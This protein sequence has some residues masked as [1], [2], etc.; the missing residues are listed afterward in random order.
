M[1][2]EGKK[3]KMD[4]HEK[5]ERERKKK[6]TSKEWL[7]ILVHWPFFPP[8]S[9]S[10]VIIISSAFSLTQQISKVNFWF[11][12]QTGRP[13]TLLTLLYSYLNFG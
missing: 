6:H 2:N 8:H 4:Q 13:F 3:R 12:L 11:A 1:F 10:I 9:L 5:I 7:H